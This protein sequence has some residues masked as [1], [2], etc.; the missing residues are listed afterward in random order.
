MKYRCGIAGIIQNGSWDKE[1]GLSKEGTDL[2]IMVSKLENLNF[3]HKV[4]KRELKWG[5]WQGVK[6]MRFVVVS[7]SWDQI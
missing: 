1:S 5:E 7:L 4:L 3:F 2:V 6:K